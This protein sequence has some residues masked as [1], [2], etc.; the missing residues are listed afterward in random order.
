[1]V[2]DALVLWRATAD[3]EASA[4]RQKRRGQRG[5]S[6]SFAESGDSNVNARRPLRKGLSSLM[7]TQ[8]G[9]TKKFRPTKVRGCLHFFPPAKVLTIAR[10][11]RRGDLRLAVTFL[12]EMPPR[13]LAFGSHNYFHL[14]VRAY[15]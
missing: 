14:F 2:L 11:R 5:S 13:A 12:F 4:L 7:V 6:A 15:F 9:K 8:T 10:A 3:A 1:V